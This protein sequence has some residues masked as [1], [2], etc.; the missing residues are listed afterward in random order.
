MTTHGINLV[1]THPQW[2]APMSFHSLVR[3]EFDK[4][5]DETYAVFNSYYNKSVFDAQGTAM[6]V[7]TVRVAGSTLYDEEDLLLAVTEQEDITFSGG[8]VIPV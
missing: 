4:I 6:S 1:V 7:T 8:E 3:A 2:G 5:N